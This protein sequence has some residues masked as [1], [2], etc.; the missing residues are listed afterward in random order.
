MTSKSK[1]RFALAWWIL[2]GVAIAASWAQA[3]AKAIPTTN[4][5]QAYINECSAAGVPI[6]PDWGDPRWVWNGPL[7]DPFIS[8]NLNAQVYFYTTSQ[9][10]CYALPRTNGAGVVKLL[11]IIC[12][13]N[14]TGRACFWDNAS[15][16]ATINTYTPISS[17]VGGAALN[18]GTDVC[19]NCHAGENIFIIHPGTALDLAAQG[20]TVMPSS[21]VQPIVHASWP[22]N[23]SVNTVAGACNGCHSQ[24]IAGR[25]PQLSTAVSGYCDVMATAWTRGSMPPGGTAD[26]PEFRAH[27]T[28]MQQACMLTAPAEPPP[29]A[30]E[31]SIRTGDALALMWLVTNS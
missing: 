10:V 11:G 21:F 23:T 5:G 3:V 28:D 29:G 13:G 8:T 20:V 19:T 7:T 4:S 15:D 2:G 25:F 9:G 31:P 17:F 18:N 14:Q 27:Y 16:I 6:P 30:R 1:Q 26:S 24:N 12:Q 22:Q